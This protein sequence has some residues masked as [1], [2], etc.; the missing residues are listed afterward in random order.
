MPRSTNTPRRYEGPNDR[1][2]SSPNGVT[3]FSLPL[4]LP[5]FSP[6]AKSRG[7]VS[8]R[9]PQKRISPRRLSDSALVNW[10]LRTVSRGKKKYAPANTGMTADYSPEMGLVFTTASFRLSKVSSWVQGPRMNPPLHYAMV[11][12]ELLFFWLI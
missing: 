7:N 4:S 2:T 3:S 11:E 12:R 8:P 5:R 9:C 6:R 10:S 1:K